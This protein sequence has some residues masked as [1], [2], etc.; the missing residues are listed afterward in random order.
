[1]DQLPSRADEHLLPEITAVFQAVDALR[2]RLHSLPTRAAAESVAIAAE[3]IAIPREARNC[4]FEAVYFGG[5]ALHRDGLPVAL[6]QQRASLELCRYLIAQRG[7]L[8][9]RDELLE[10]LWP[11]AL[12][13]ANGLHRLHVAVSTL[14][15]LVD[16]DGTSRG[17]IQLEGACYSV[18]TQA[19]ETDFALFDCRYSEAKQCLLRG[20]N[21]GAATAF[22][23]AITLYH[24]DYL[25]DHP[26][27]EWTHL[28]RDHY[29]ER[30][31]T[32]LAVLCEGAAR[33]GDLHTVIDLATDILAVDNLRETA[34]RHLMRARYN[35]GERGLALRQYES[36]ARL[37]R[38]ELGVAP[39][40][41]TIRLH[42]AIRDDSPLPLEP[43]SLP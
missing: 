3:P 28:L 2:Q 30:R 22:R 18:P 29:R 5:F 42:E 40:P 13:S 14:R 15:R 38:D 36:C 11:D 21:H 27:A 9:P 12:D 32:A 20:D 8:V 23:A 1:M 17:L 24:G 26:Y 19:V 6:G 7:R 41:I 35:S 10:V 34:H 39:A 43:T 31:L 16:P 4:C 33:A 37:L 25:A